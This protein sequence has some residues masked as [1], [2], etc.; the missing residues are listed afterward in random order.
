MGRDRF[1]GTEG[2][3]GDE[4]GSYSTWEE[5]SDDSTCIRAD[6]DSSVVLTWVIG[7]A[8]TRVVLQSVEFATA[9]AQ[10]E[11][12]VFDSVINEPRFVV[13]RLKGFVSR[14]LTPA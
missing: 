6:P 14:S 3:R 8:F 2:P 5:R 9:I 4:H 7:F 10:V 1:A 13:H 12:G 11:P